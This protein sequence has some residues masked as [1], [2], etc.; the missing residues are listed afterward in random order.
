VQ[1]EFTVSLKLRRRAYTVLHIQLF[2]YLWTILTCVKDKL[3]NLFK[4]PLYVRACMR[5]CMCACIRA[6]MCLC[7]CMLVCLVPSA[8]TLMSNLTTD[9]S[10]YIYTWYHTLDRAYAGHLD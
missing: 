8:I 3:T 10:V 4:E 5:A 7:A 6:C 2:G 1:I 9:R